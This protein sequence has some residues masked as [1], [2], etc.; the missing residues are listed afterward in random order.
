VSGTGSSHRAEAL[1]DMQAIIAAH[2]PDSH[3]MCVGCRDNG[4]DETYPCQPVTYAL[5]AA[6]LLTQRLVNG[7]DT[8]DDD[9]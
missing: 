3:G 6:D 5:R 9:A 8:P 2:V 1:A 7:T 4:D